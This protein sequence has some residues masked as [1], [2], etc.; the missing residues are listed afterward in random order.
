M[1]KDIMMN[2]QIEKKNK[3]IKRKKIKRRQKRTRRMGLG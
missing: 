1:N 2:D 3:K